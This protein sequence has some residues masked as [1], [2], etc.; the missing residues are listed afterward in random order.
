[1][2]THHPGVMYE[3]H[4][5]GSFIAKAVPMFF[6]WTEKKSQ[7]KKSRKKSHGKKSQE[8]KS[9]EKKSQL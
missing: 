3:H 6:G 4:K 1:M 5:R 2:M 8:I 7:E 9:Q